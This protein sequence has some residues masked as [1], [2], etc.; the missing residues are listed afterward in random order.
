MHH[1]FTEIRKHEGNKPI[2]YLKPPQTYRKTTLL[3]NP[4]QKPWFRWEPVKNLP[5]FFPL[6]LRLFSSL[7]LISN[8]PASERKHRSLAPSEIVRSR[9]LCSAIQTLSVSQLSLLSLGRSWNKEYIG[10]NLNDAKCTQ[11]PLTELS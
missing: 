5:P 4:P 2:K 9:R 1:S 8:R 7:G 3:A 6:D 10:L 11:K